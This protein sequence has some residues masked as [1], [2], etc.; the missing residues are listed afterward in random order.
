MS[1]ELLRVDLEKL[2][3]QQMEKVFATIP[4]ACE[5][6]NSEWIDRDYYV[7]HLIETVLRIRLNNEVDAYA[8][9]NIYKNV[10]T[11][12]PLAQMLSRYLAEESGH[13]HMFLRDIEKFGVTK[14]EVD[15]TLPFFSTR[16]LIGYI[17]LSITKDGPMPT[18]IWNWFVEWYSDHY[19]MVIT[20][21]AANT[22]GS[23]LV[24][25]S[26]SHL[27]YDESHNHD[28]LMFGTVKRIVRNTD[29]KKKA[30]EYLCSFVHL[31]GQ[32]FKELHDSTIGSGAVL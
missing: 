17:Y 6:H 3:S 8:L 16:Q 2:A 1:E 23:R 11:D 21:K 31:I 12:I 28:D 24:K 29:D 32:Y 14:R 10:P 4:R 15:A 27:N 9:Y 5:F 7:R 13:E 18:M 30:V 22:F 26:L 25:G 19:N 20:Q